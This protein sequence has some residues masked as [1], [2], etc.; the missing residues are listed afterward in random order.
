MLNGKQNLS[1]DELLADFARIRQV[2]LPVR[3]ALVVRLAALIA[4]LSSSD[5]SAELKLVSRRAA[6]R[7]QPDDQMLTAKEAAPMLRRGVR[8][9]YR[10]ADR[11]PFVKRIS[12]RSILCS[13]AGIQ[14]WLA[15][16]PANWHD[17]GHEKH[18]AGGTH[19]KTDGQ[20]V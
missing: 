3:S 15:V 9:I 12:C 6:A 10:N 4:A 16:N 2:P 18:Q 20:I 11:L 5:E 19:A 7:L 14:K 1:V 13:K 17:A 8:W